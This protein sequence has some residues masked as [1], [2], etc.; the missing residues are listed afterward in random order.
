MIQSKST[1]LLILHS[2]F[3]LSQPT[4]HLPHRTAVDTMLHPQQAGWEGTAVLQDLDLDPDLG[5][6]SNNQAIVRLHRIPILSAAAVAAVAGTVDLQHRQR[7]L[8]RFRLLRRLHWLGCRLI[9]G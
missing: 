2:V 3:N 6:D 1:R 4:N 7:A 8:R 9:S 5:T